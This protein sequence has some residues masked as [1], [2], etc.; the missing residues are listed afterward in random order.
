MGIIL[1]VG[2]NPPGYLVS[3][4]VWTAGSFDSYSCGG[5]L[6]P[7]V[8]SRILNCGVPVWADNSWSGRLRG[9]FLQNVRAPLRL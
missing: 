5:G 3:G 2:G 4:T 1:D 9:K 8:G 6:V 7:P